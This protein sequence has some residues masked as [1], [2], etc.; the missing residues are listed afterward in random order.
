M[1]AVVEVLKGLLLGLVRLRA[2]EG[3]RLV[4]DVGRHSGVLGEG[5]RAVV[6][7]PRVPEDEVSRVG[8]DLLP[9]ATFFVN[10]PL[11]HLGIVQVRV[12]AGPASLGLEVV[13]LEEALVVL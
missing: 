4:A 10:H 13:K 11:Q 3:G 8:A 6:D 2:G 1:R 5:D 9:V 7:R 12:G